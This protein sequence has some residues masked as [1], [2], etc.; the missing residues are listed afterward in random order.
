MGADLQCLEGE[1][2]MTTMRIMI[3]VTARN[4]MLREI[5]PCNLHMHCCIPSAT[6]SAPPLHVEATTICHALRQLIR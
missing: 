6:A 5:V 1:I 4:P 3:A 2:A